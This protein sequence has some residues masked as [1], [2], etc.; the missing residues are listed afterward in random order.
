MRS[1]VLR[2]SSFLVIAAG[3]I[4]W[5]LTAD[6]FCRSTT[7]TSDC[8]VDE[9]G[10]KT[11]GAS[12]FWRSSCVGI[13]LQRD[14]SRHIP[15]DVARKPILSA[16]GSWSR[17]PCPGG[18]GTLAFAELAPAACHR[19]EFN[20]DGPNANVVMFQD[21]K[22][23]YLA[24]DNLLAKTTVTYDPDTGELLDAD[25]ELNHA[26]NELTVSDTN[27]V[28]DVES[29][30]VHE[31]GH[32]LG[33]DHTDDYQAV[34]NAQHTAQYEAGRDLADDDLAAVCAVY[35][36]DSAAKCDTTPHGGF[37]GDCAADPAVDEGCSAAPAPKPGRGW[38]AAEWMVALGLVALGLRR[39]AICSTISSCG[40]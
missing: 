9:H 20:E 12:L 31:A 19:I 37:S 38:L 27:I 16:F 24:Q 35:P 18:E 39:R 32:V 23:V 6:A 30:M 36:P 34:M 29:I 15:F 40:R 3:A 33:L 8:G 4:G 11:K 28:Y 7:C 25:V 17:A 5:P 10:C 14:A 1:S 26:L 13:S 21:D 22:W 2:F